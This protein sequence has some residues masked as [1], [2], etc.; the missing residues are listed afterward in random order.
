MSSTIDENRTGLSSVKSIRVGNSEK[1]IN[2][3]ELPEEIRSIFNLYDTDGDGTI[4][5]VELTEAAQAYK[6]L[7]VQNSLFRKGLVFTSFL[8]V[9]L[10]ATVGGITYG[11][12]SASKDTKVE[13]RSLMTKDAKPVGIN[14]NEEF[15]TFG[16][17]AFMPRDVPSKISEIILHAPDGAY[18]Y[19]TKKSIEITP[20]ESVVFKT[21]DGD[22]ISWESDNALDMQVTLVDGTTWSS[23]STCSECSAT[24]VVVDEAITKARADFEEFVQ[25]E[26]GR[27]LVE[28]G[29]ELS[30]CRGGYRARKTVF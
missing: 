21:L 19:R 29:R 11:I 26:Y 2:V 12:V 17:L 3:D 1:V 13:S 9:A 10:V 22:I 6:T 20:N 7:K 15:I 25:A 23:R 16:S 24:S 8:A 28:H 14:L 30:Y 18:Y 4:T 5:T 27:E